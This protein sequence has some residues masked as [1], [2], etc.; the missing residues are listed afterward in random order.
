MVLFCVF[1]A[2]F[3]LSLVLVPVIRGIALR[4]GLVDKPDNRRKTHAK[5]TPVAGGIAVFLSLLA[6]V[7]GMLCF[8]PDDLAACYFQIV[9][10]LAGGLLICLV[11]VADDF[12]RLRGRHKLL[13]QVAA[14]CVVIGSGVVVEHVHLLWWKI[15]LGLLSIPFTICFLLG[16]INSL[17]LLDGMDGLLGSVAVI[18]CATIACL[19]VL[20]GRP[21]DAIVALALAGAVLGFLRYNYPPASIFLGDCGSMLIGLVVGTLAIVTSVK[22]STTIVLST[23]VALLTLP[24]MD[25]TAAILRRKLTGRSIYSTDRGHLH[26]CLLR[27]GYSIPRVLAIVSACC[28]V[29]GISVL[30]SQTF[31][32]E[33]IALTTSIAVVVVL[34]VTGLFGSAEA[35]LVK[36]RLVALGS[37]L[38][39]PR[40]EGRAKQLEVRLQGSVDWNTLWNAITDKAEALQLRQVRLDV[41]APSLHENYHARWEISTRETEHDTQWRVEIPI[42]I[43]TIDVGRILIVGSSDSEAIWVAIESI[44][45]LIEEYS[46]LVVSGKPHEPVALETVNENKAERA[47]EWEETQ[48]AP[49]PLVSSEVGG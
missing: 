14:V 22:A 35:I 32:N 3:A 37:S 39:T 6:V 48:E 1:T 11:G 34:V 7:G 30:L 40:T 27:R 25:T 16:A 26:H 15:D 13:G 42:S 23:P 17:N 41:N 44:T 5:V 28:F 4:I 8:R 29:T 43:R 31:Q 45:A 33:L 24:F 21:S 20:T 38:L 18:V 10:L 47:S 12:G 36:E 46:H 19:A 2:S 9:G 49:A